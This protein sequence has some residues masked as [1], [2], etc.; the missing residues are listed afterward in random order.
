MK[1]I[2]L[3]TP[4]ASTRS[5]HHHRSRDDKTA[6]RWERLCGTSALVAKHHLAFADDDFVDVLEERLAEQ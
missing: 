2:I 5:T 1:P 6:L 3:L 4:S